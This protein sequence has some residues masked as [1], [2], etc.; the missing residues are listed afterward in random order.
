MRLEYLQYLIEVSR[1]T[2]M[3]EA[4]KALHLTP[5]TLS[6]AI[7]KL[8]EELHTKLIIADNKGTVLT[9][10]GKLLAEKSN[11]FFDFL[12]N[13]KGVQPPEAKLCTIA[14]LA[15]YGIRDDFLTAFAQTAKN[16]LPQMI[17]H[18]TYT[19]SESLISE[20]LANTYDLGLT[21]NTKING[22]YSYEIPDK[23]AFVPLFKCNLYC[24]AHKNSIAASYKTISLNTLFRL[25]IPILSPLSDQQKSLTRL[26]SHFT[27]SPKIETLD[28]Y[29][30]FQQ[31]LS[32]N[33]GV[34]ISIM[35]IASAAHIPITMANDCVAVKLNDDISVHLGYLIN[36]DNASENSNIFLEYLAA[37]IHDYTN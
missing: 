26:L 9:E 37:Y 29:L 31:S 2:S 34:T 11:E 21:Y 13:L 12:A 4:S 33:L 25:N 18:A 20:F 36:K 17:I 22:K 15:A 24:I 16:A 5:P 27:D 35:S 1:H 3:S 7:N 32:N 6:I 14:L 19:D 8:E 30:L 28:S 10:K 23:L